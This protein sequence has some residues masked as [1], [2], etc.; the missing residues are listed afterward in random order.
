M[1][2]Q[3]CPCGTEKYFADCCGAF[4]AVKK[5]PR[6]AEE[7]MRSRYS[8]YHNVDM[9]YIGKTMKSPAADN[10]NPKDAK[11]WAS[12]IKWTQLEVIRS[13]NNDTTGTVEFR[14]HYTLDGK[15]HILHEVSE[16]IFEEGRWYYTE[17]S[18][19]EV[20]TISA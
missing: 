7:L 2:E 8:A 11:K 1:T 6:T 20:D 5:I 10:F 3:T 12:K 4:L 15:M 9:D 18:R 19:R 13:S 14:A 17:C 16:F